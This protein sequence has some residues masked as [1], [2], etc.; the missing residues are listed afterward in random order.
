MHRLLGPVIVALA[1]AS[2]ARAADM[3]EAGSDGAFDWSGFHVGAFGGYGKLGASG[4]FG[5]VSAGYDWRFDTVV[6]GVEGDVAGGGLDGRRDGGSYDIDAFGTIRA[7]VG[8]AFDR[9]VVYGTGGV[10]FASADYARGGRRDDAGQAGWAAGFGLE[11]HLFGGVSAKVEYLYVDLDRRGF[12]VGRTVK[13]DSSGGQVR[14]GL[15]YRF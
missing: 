8:Y 4:P 6:V 7:R 9:F 10:A 1:L 13:L 15:N 12:D 3:T 11:A 2:P 14:L 5:G